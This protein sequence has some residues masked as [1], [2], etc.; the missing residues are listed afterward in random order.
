MVRFRLYPHQYDRYGA[1]TREAPLL[2]IRSIRS[3][4]GHITMRPVILT[5]LEIGGQKWKIELTLVDREIMGFRMLLGRQAIRHRF[6][7][8]AAR[9]YVAGKDS[10]RIRKKG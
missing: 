1:V 5:E 7:I 10:A 4:V 2:E 8:D 9:S 6:F 3:S